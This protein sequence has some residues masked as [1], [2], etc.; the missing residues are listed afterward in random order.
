LALQ[1]FEEPASGAGL[2]FLPSAKL[3]PLI[4]QREKLLESKIMT[5]T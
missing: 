1:Q 3:M 4:K 2:A 5:G